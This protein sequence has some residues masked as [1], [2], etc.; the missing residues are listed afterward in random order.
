MEQLVYAVVTVT[1]YQNHIVWVNHIDMVQRALPYKARH[2]FAKSV[3]TDLAKPW[4]ANWSGGVQFY[5]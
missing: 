2:G 1:T 4:R 5:I 3:I